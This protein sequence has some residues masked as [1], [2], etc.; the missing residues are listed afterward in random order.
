MN[1]IEKAFTH[2]LYCPRKQLVKQAIATAFPGAIVAQQLSCTLGDS[3]LP[4]PRAM[5]ERSSIEIPAFRQEL[6]YC[7]GA[8]A[9]SCACSP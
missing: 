5:C 8:S 4:V 9:A 6:S 1:E 7:L 3:H 2:R